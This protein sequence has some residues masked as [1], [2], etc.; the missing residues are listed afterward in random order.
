[1]NHEYYN[2]NPSR[3]AEYELKEQCAAREPSQVEAAL[4]E[5]IALL[6]DLSNELIQTKRCFASVLIPE[7]EA[8]GACSNTAPSPAKSPLCYAIT[9]QSEL[10]RSMLADLRSINNRSTV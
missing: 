8:T 10:L 9:S 7:H 3:L 2:A 6:N 1:M 4:A 5:H